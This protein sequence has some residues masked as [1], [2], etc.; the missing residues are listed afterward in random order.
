MD[1]KILRTTSIYGPYDNFDKEKSH[2]VPSLIKKALDK[3]KTLSVWG[4]KNTI[5]DFVFVSDL[6]QASMKLV[7][8]SKIN[9]PL[10][11]SS[12]RPTAIYDLSK[13]ILSVLKKNKKIK[14]IYKGR[15][16]ANYRVLD[17]K[18][19]NKILNFKKRTKLE[20]GLKITID[21]Y[22]KKIK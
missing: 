16:S 22:E 14:F 6:V 12:G 7:T 10:N 4:S 11:F 8:K 3:N 17:N 19:I 5:R 2:V 13:M 9:Y 18:K 21:W 1:I 20:K 15:S